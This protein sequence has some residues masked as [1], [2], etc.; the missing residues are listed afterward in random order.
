M[1]NLKCKLATK[2]KN[3]AHF[4][5]LF[6]EKES[7][8]NHLRNLEEELDAQVARVEAQAREEARAKFENE[9]RNIEERME[10]ETAELQAHLKLFQ[11]VNYNEK[12]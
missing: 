2:F 12:S 9:K 10:T 5:S 7:H 3:F 4:I 11:K 8:L 1:L 6:R